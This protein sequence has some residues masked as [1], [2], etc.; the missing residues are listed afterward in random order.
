MRRGNVQ[1]FLAKLASNSIQLCL[2]DH[3]QKLHAANFSLV[4]IKSTSQITGSLN[5]CNSLK[6]RTR[7]TTA[8]KFT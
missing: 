8:P 5:F 6:Y 4:L 7:R 3:L 1:P 2:M